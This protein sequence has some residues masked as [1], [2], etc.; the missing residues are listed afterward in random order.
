MVHYDKYMNFIEAIKDSPNFRASLLENELY[1]VG[2]RKRIE[3]LIKTIDH[4]LSL[5][6]QLTAASGKLNICFAEAWKSMKNNDPVS[7]V[8]FSTVSEGFSKIMNTNGSVH[9]SSFLSMRNVLFNFLKSDLEKLSE[10]KSQFNSISS[11]LEEA[12]TKKACIPKQKANELGEAKN[13]LTAIGTC[14]AHV[15]VD[16]V[17]QINLI[18]AK[19]CYVLIEAIWKFLNEGT[20]YY[21]KSYKTLIDFVD[22]EGQEIFNTITNLKNNFKIMEKKMQDRHSVVPKELFSLPTGLSLDPEV[23]MEGYLFKRSSNAF[24]S[25]N[26]RWFQI[27]DN[28][29]MYSHKNNDHEP[30][31]VMEN[32]LKLCLVRPAPPNIER[33]CCFEL[34]T[35]CKSYMLQADSDLLCKTWIRALQRTIQHLHEESFQKPKKDVNFDNVSNEQQE[36]NNDNNIN[37]LCGFESNE[38]N[39]ST[40][41]QELQKIDSQDEPIKKFKNVLS[42]REFYSHVRSLPGNTICADC[43][44]SDAKWISINLGIIICIECSGVHR[45]LGVHISKVR[46]LTMDS[47][48]SK[49]QEVMLSLGNDIVNSIYMKYYNYWGKEYPLI[50]KDSPRS[51]REYFIKAK[52]V[53]KIFTEKSPTLN[54][55]IKI[56]DNNFEDG[57]SYVNHQYLPL[58]TTET[59]SIKSFDRS[60]SR[61]SCESETM[62]FDNSGNDELFLP[63]MVYDVIKNN[64]IVKMLELLANGFDIN[65]VIQGNTPLHIAVKYSNQGM[66]EFLILNGGKINAFNEDLDTPLHIAVKIGDPLLV[67]HLIK[68]NADKSIKNKRGLTPLECAMEN[69]HANVVVLFRL[70]DLKNECTNVDSNNTMLDENIDDFLSNLQI[71]ENEYKETKI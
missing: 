21:K 17:A 5:E 66:I 30:L 45:S 9:E 24:K 15:S 53:K 48:E 22:K 65:S 43:R 18:H 49:Q 4:V 20:N 52:Y 46:S 37:N 29:L 27:K 26:R 16:Y 2:F 40:P 47:L 55:G 70:V 69:E 8:T 33:S 3:E 28:K 71:Q 23:V 67:Y 68:R 64:N 35:P 50:V 51:E 13:S 44:C 36:H 38:S 62:K 10:T 14:Y 39:T 63:D 25:W 42:I 60:E 34:V 56:C 58:P 41:R 54:I 1:L 7:D 6:E 19:K 32:N 11:N 31:R 59:L 57:D 12:L 61:L